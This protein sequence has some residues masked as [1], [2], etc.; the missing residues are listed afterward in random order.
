MLT[1]GERLDAFHDGLL[2]R[3]GPARAAELRA[4][5]EALVASGVEDEALREGDAAPDFVLPDQHGG[6]IGL[7]DRLEQRDSAVVLFFRGGWC[8]YCAITLRAWQDRLPDIR[9]AGSQ[10]LALSPQ[11]LN[12]CCETAERDMLDFAVLSDQGNLVAERYGVAYDLP[13]RLR[14]FFQ[15]LG[16][17]LPRV[18]GTGDWRLPLAATFIVDRNRRIVRRHVSALHYRRLEPSDALATLRGIAAPSGG[19]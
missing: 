1:L 12:A 9:A 13:E 19:D 6:R 17:D 18:N 5:E 15:S 7:Y 4:S 16:H 8:P 10:V 3:V 2:D 11:R 14:P